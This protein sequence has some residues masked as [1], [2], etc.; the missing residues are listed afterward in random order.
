MQTPTRPASPRPCNRPCRCAPFLRHLQENFV[1]IT[2]L[3]LVSSTVKEIPAV[4]RFGARE[5]LHSASYC[6]PDCMPGELAPPGVP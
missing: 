1:P 4:Q 5:S 3:H 2:H 6:C